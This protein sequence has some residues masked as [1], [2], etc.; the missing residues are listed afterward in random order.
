MSSVPLLF[1]GG[2][3]KQ[4]IEFYKKAIDAEASDE[5]DLTYAVVADDVLKKSWGSDDPNLL[6]KI[7]YAE[8]T[9]G[10][11]RNG[12][13]A[14]ADSVRQEDQRHLS[15]AIE[16]ASDDVNEAKRWFDNLTEHGQ[17][18]KEWG[19]TFWTEGFGIV[20]DQFEFEWRV[21]GPLIASADW[22]KE[23]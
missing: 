10:R 17:A 4:A 21:R 16:L 19:P 15:L 22:E 18:Y 8:L 6:G 14:L 9:F 20:L 13:I 11:G 7:F 12:R 5:W 23:A 3:C 2:N 1:F